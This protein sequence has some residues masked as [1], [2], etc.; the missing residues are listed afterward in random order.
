MKDF[1]RLDRFSI[2]TKVRCWKPGSPSH[3]ING[4][5]GVVSWAGEG[6]GRVVVLDDGLRVKPLE[7]IYFLLENEYV[8]HSVIES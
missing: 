1:S 4:L 7:D 8:V 6:N 2:G 3:S 5:F